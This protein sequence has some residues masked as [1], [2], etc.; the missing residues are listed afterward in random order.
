MMSL[1][2][3]W[4]DWIKGILA[5]PAAVMMFILIAGN[6]RTKKQWLWAAGMAGYVALYYFF[7]V[8]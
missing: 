6:P 1:A 7:V 8:R 3:G 4:P 5:V 2:S